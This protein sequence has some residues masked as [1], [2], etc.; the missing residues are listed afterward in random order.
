MKPHTPR[1]VRQRGDRRAGP[2]S[3]LAYATFA[4]G[5]ALAAE[6]MEPYGPTGPG[7][8]GRSEFADSSRTGIV[9]KGFENN[10]PD[11]CDDDMF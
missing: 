3:S 8:R 4:E 10:F 2:S 7:G 11:V 5:G 6:I 1:A 9:H